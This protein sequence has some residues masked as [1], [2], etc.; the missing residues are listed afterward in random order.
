MNTLRDPGS[1]RDPSGY[2]FVRG[3]RILRSVNRRAKRDFMAAFDSG[4]I[5]RLVASGLMIE[6]SVQEMS[7]EELEQFRGPRDD[8]P[9]LVLMHP[10][11]PFISYYEWTF[12]QLRMRRSRISRRS[13]P[14]HDGFVLSDATHSMRFMRGVCVTSMCCR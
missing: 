13:R 2:V 3:E 10:R 1:F 8:L 14:S 9:E 4:V 5:A 12:G 6:T 11:I 7:A